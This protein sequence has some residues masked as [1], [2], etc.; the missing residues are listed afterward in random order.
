MLPRPC[1]PKPFVPGP[2]R[3]QLE[4]VDWLSHK[5]LPFDF[6]H[7]RLLVSVQAP[8]KDSKVDGF[9]FP[10]Y[11]MQPERLMRLINWER[12]DHPPAK[13]STYEVTLESH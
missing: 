10:I 6:P 13:A 1:Q 8:V 2:F 12:A 3:P 5:L 11:A 4:Y 7:L 9:L